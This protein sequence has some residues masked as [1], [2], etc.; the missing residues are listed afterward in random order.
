VIL[1]DTCVVSEPV[2]ARPDPN[3]LRWLSAH[4]GQLYLSALTLGELW[5]GLARLDAGPRRERLSVWIEQLG[6]Q[7][8][9]R[10]LPIDARVAARW[11]ELCATAERKGTPLGVIDGLLAATAS[12]HGLSVATRNV[13]DFAPAGVPVVNPWLDP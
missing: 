6:A 12:T 1:L 4:R 2:R 3:V 13:A 9:D 7:H 11:G 5:K 8:A 10:T